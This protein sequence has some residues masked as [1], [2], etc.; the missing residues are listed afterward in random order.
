[1]V[2][3]NYN[4][5]KY[6]MMCLDYVIVHELSHFIYHDHQK[7]FWILHDLWIVR[8]RVKQHTYKKCNEAK[9]YP[10]VKTWFTEH[11]HLLPRI[12]FHV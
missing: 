5:V 9:R 7:G 1:M 6:E 10:R 2:T 8:T 12:I 3:L 4:L 11:E